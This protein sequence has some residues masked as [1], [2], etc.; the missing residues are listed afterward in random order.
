MNCISHALLLFS[1]S[2]C[3]GAEAADPPLSIGKATEGAENVQK[4]MSVLLPSD[5]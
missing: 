4:G 3:L 2:L 5:G 1:L